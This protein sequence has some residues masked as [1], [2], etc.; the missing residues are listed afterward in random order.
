M[1]AL[2]LLTQRR[3]M[4][5]L[6]SP[7]PSEAVLEQILQAGMRAPDHGALRPWEFVVAEGAGLNK[8]SSL[9][10]EAAIKD[11]EPIK[12]IQKAVKAPYRAPLII[13]VIART[14]EHEKVPYIEQVISA[15]CAV[16]AMQMAAVAQ[17]FQGIWRTGK[18]AYHSLIRHAFRLNTEDAI[19]GFLYIGT[20][21]CEISA[22]LPRDIKES[23]K[24]L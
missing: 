17:G 18:W 24:Y 14:K 9:F 19:V 16:Q 21:E 4:G 20:P 13:M 6:I 7:G 3:S 5:R 2:T 12:A 11:E 15:G 23:V 1:D 10:E 8:L 22:P